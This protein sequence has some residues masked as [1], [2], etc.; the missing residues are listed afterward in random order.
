MFSRSFARW[1]LGFLGLFH[2]INGV[3]M[4]LAPA[5]W[6][7]AVPGVAE[8]GPF[9]PHFVMDIGFAFLASGAGFL[10]ALWRGRTATTLALAG[11]IWPAL[12]ALFH[13]W[14]WIADHP[15]PTAQLWV[16]E[17]LGVVLVGLLGL[18]LAVQQFRKGEA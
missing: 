8:T 5:A 17:G 13:V 16:S 4:L 10:A 7:A 18:A 15:P 1:F 11:S 14:E 3:Y 12:H 6:Y 9:N 2:G